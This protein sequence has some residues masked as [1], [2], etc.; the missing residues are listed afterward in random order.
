MRIHKGMAIVISTVSVQLLIHIYPV[1]K[2]KGSKKCLPEHSIW[3]MCP[4]FLN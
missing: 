1:H 2:D 3:F 4:D